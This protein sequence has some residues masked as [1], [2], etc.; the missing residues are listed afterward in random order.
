[1]DYGTVMLHIFVPD[2]REYYNL[3]ALWA[4]GE[5]TEIPDVV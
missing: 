2:F 4:D 5:I 3:E 1:M